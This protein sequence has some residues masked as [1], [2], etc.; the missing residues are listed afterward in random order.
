MSRRCACCAGV[1]FG[2]DCAMPTWERF[3]ELVDGRVGSNRPA[4]CE[5]L[6]PWPRKVEEEGDTADVGGRVNGDGALRGAV[7][8]GEWVP[9]TE[10]A[11]DRA[12]ER[13]G[14][15]KLCKLLELALLWEVKLE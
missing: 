15:E 10:R 7:S 3:D 11:A 4:F 2:D 13:F 8:L 12:V 6:R 1:T 14:R 5:F 9:A